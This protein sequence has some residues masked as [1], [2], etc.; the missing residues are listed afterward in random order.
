MIRRP[1]IIMAIFGIS[2][3]VTFIALG[4]VSTLALD[5][6]KERVRAEEEAALEQGLRLAL[7]RM[8]SALSAFIATESARPYYVYDQS[9]SLEDTSFPKEF[10]APGE[11]DKRSPSPLSGKKFEHIKLHFQ[12]GPDGNISS[13]QAGGAP[14]TEELL[15]QLGRIVDRDSLL[16]TLGR[17]VTPMPEKP[18]DLLGSNMKEQRKSISQAAQSDREWYNRAKQNLVANAQMMEV[19]K[20]DMPEAGEY[21]ESNIMKPLWIKGRLFLARAVQRDTGVYI[22]GAWLDWDGLRKSLTSRIEDLLPGARLVSADESAVGQPGRMLAALPVKLEPGPLP[23]N[24]PGRRSAVGMVLAV[25]WTGVLVAVLA[26]GVL[27]VGAVSLG[28][29][30]AAFVSAVTHELRTPLTT[31]RMYTEMLAEGMITDESKKAAYIESLRA[32]S[33]RL[34]HLVENVLSYARLERGKSGGVIQEITIEELLG[35]CLE[36]LSDHCRRSGTDFE[37]KASPEIMTVNVLADPQA[38][39]RVL[40]NLVDNAIK[41]ANS[42]DGNNIRLEIKETEKMVRLSICDSGPGIRRK[43]AQRL[44]RPFSKSDRAVA[45][46]APGVGLGLFLSRKLARNI[47]GDLHL[48][49]KQTK[50]SCFVLSLKKCRS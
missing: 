3:A 28:E 30:R 8:D 25:A 47:G 4:L 9:Y 38:V 19:K 43:E 44:F 13:P 11:Q 37:L 24:E 35:R 2:L 46:S 33:E 31:F 17:D 26:V 34:G 14:Q 5:L 29:R 6:E 42:G 41:Y 50:G 36:G 39:E 18:P 32:E 15:K 48:D 45:D 16:A 7:W 20:M 21:L 40:F 27:L 12:V 23:E 49:N 10:Y 1:W 22:Q